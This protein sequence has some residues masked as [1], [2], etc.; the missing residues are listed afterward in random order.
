LAGAVCAAP[1]LHQRFLA[2]FPD[3]RVRPWSPAGR[4]P[5]TAGRTR[6]L[7]GR[8][9]PPFLPRVDGIVDGPAGRGS[10][11]AA[12]ELLFC[13]ILTR[14]LPTGGPPPTNIAEFRVMTSITGPPA[15][16]RPQPPATAPI[17]DRTTGHAAIVRRPRNIY[18]PAVPRRRRPA[19]WP[20]PRFRSSSPNRRP[21]GTFDHTDDRPAGNHAPSPRAI[22]GFVE[23]E[24]S[25]AA[26]PNR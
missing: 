14:T 10:G 21:A 1:P 20:A 24:A 25:P 4:T 8:A 18:A 17:R 9:R 15:V 23:I 11:A 7:P 2:R 3:R 12:A 26:A 22:S 13:Q 19:D 5:T 16:R 6:K